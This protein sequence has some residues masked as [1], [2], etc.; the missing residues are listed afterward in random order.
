MTVRVAINGF[1]RIGRNDFRAAREGEHRFEIVAVN[2]LADACVH[3]GSEPAAH[4]PRLGETLMI[5]RNDPN[6]TA[7]AS[8]AVIAARFLTPVVHSAQA[9]AVNLKQA[10]W[11]VRGSNFIAIH[12]LLDTIAANAREAADLAAERVVA[13]DLPVDARLQ[14]IADTVDFSEVAPGFSSAEET[15]RAAVRDIDDVRRRVALAIA[16]LDGHDLPSQDLVVGVMATLDRDRW[17]LASHL[18][19]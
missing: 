10:H 2:D 4:R 9:L 16:E 14:T 3:R 5:T 6:D 8:S 15:V 7:S 12:E 13:L 1:G 11:N 17:L 19:V 18:S